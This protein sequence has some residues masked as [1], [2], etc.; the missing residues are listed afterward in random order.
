MR[1]PL[2]HLSVFSGCHFHVHVSIQCVHGNAILFILVLRWHMIPQLVS[3]ELAQTTIFG[4]IL[5]IMAA[6]SVLSK[7]FVYIGGKLYL[8]AFQTDL[9][10]I[11]GASFNVFIYIGGNDILSFL[12][13]DENHACFIAFSRSSPKVC[14]QFTKRGRHGCQGWEPIRIKF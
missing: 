8:F 2:D 9:L 12:K 5:L 11:L 4:P 7:H 6:M 13:N 1:T 10:F 14:H 3:L